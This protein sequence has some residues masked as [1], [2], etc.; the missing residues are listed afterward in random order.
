MQ[1]AL[2]RRRFKSI[3]N[4]SSHKDHLLKRR[5]YKHQQA[6]GQAKEFTVRKA[7]KLLKNAIAT[8]SM[9]V[10]FKRESSHLI[11]ETMEMLMLNNIV[12]NEAPAKLST[13][14]PPFDDP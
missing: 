3:A 10:C 7:R 12:C 5:R 6:D 11:W 14:K 4:N 2:L 13:G 9:V 1:Q 8:V